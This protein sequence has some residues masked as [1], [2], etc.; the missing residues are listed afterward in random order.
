MI[1]SKCIHQEVCYYV[2]DCIKNSPDLLKTLNNCNSFKD[3]DLMTE[4]PCKIGTKIWRSIVHCTFVGICN[5]YCE[6]LKTEDMCE[7]WV[8]NGCKRLIF[9]TE[10]SSQL[11]DEMDKTVFL[12]KEQAKQ[13]LKEM[14]K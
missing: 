1:C 12:T 9:E 8:D 14:N 7:R 10:F 13:K 11:F 5:I 3:K 4:L 6:N 2:Y